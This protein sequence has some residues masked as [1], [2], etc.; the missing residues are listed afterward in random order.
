MSEKLP[1]VTAD[2]VIR[3]LEH[4]GFVLARQSGSHKIYRNEKGKRVTVPYHSEKVLHPK[5]LKSILRDADLTV[6]RLKELIK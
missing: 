4:A 6:E 1:R 5:V 3:A 2:K